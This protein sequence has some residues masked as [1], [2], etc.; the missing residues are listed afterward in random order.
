MYTRVNIESIS[1]KLLNLDLNDGTEC[2][3]NMFADV[4]K[5]GGDADI[6]EGHVAIQMADGSK[7]TRQ[8]FMI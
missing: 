4:T 1:V 3:L 6:P 2:V 5:L 8:T 7:S